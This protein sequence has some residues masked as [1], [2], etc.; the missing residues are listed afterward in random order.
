MMVG[1]GTVKVAVFWTDLG[2]THTPAEAHVA[3]GSGSGCGQEAVGIGELG[4]GVGLLI[5]AEERGGEDDT[6]GEEGVGESEG[7][8]VDG[9]TGGRDKSTGK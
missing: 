9:A 6:A 8:V 4:T 1:P 7:E 3:S 5:G 2:T